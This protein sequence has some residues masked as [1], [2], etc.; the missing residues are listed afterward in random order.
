VDAAGCHHH[1]PP[2]RAGFPIFA[3][4]YR[5]PGGNCGLTDW[6][7]GTFLSETPISRHPAKCLMGRGFGR[8]LVKRPM[9]CGTVG[10]LGA[11]CCA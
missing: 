6:Q 1:P 9:A 3:W 11:Q 5:N 10:L 8:F 4:S 2:P 7:T